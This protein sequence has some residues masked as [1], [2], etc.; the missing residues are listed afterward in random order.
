MNLPSQ[1]IHFD[2]T[3]TAI[4]LRVPTAVIR[5]PSTTITLFFRTWLDAG[6]I[7]VPATSAIF[8]A[9]AEN[10]KVNR[11]RAKTEK[12]RF[13]GTLKPALGTSAL[14]G[15]EF[16]ARDSSVRA[17]LANSL[18][19][20]KRK[21][22]RSETPVRLALRAGSALPLFSFDQRCGCAV[23]LGEIEMSGLKIK[24]VDHDLD[25]GGGW[26]RQNGAE[27]SEQRGHG[28]G[29]EQDV[30]RMQAHLLAQHDRKEQV[31][32]DLTDDQD[33][34][35]REPEFCPAQAQGDKQDRDGNKKGPDVGQKLTEKREHPEHQRGLHPNDPQSYAD[36]KARDATIDGNAARPHDHLPHQPRER[37]MRLFAVT[38]RGE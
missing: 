20:T 27:N 38:I 6:L 14:S 18:G 8:S 4:S 29:K 13:G 5:S 31:Q 11:R 35:K 22:S 23:D 10:E 9:W 15:V 26:H 33:D 32:F 1:S 7:S 34:Q 24:F 17:G 37:A 16:I 28:E 2:P 36:G 3:G 19:M 12:I 21:L 30:D 25:N